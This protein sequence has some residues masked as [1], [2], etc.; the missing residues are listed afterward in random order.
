[1]ASDRLYPRYLADRLSAALSDTPVVVIHGPRQCG[2]TTLARAFGDSAGYSYITLD[3]PV[4]LSA[5]RADPTGFVLD[6][7][8]RAILDEVQRA[9][10]L[11]MPIKAS[12]DRERRPGRLILTGS[13]NMLFV[14]QIAD[15]LVG[16]ME[17]MRLHPLSQDEMA[18][19]RPR[20][21]RALF[22]GEFGL[23]R[24][25]RLGLGLVERI[26]AGGYPAAIRRASPSRRAA[27]YRDY[28]A[29]L[30][31]RDVRDLVRVGTREALGRLLQFAA[32]RN[33]Q[34]LNTADM[35]AACGV[36]RP[37]AGEY[38]SLLERLFLVDQLP[39]WHT[40]RLS[41]LV[42]APKLYLTDTG[43][44]CALIG[45]MA[46]AMWQSRSEMGPLL[47]AFVLQELRRQAS[48]LEE[49]AV[50][51][52]FR[53]RDG[54]EVD[55]VVEHGR[56]VVGLEVKAG[57]TVTSS[58]FRGLR[59]LRD[60]AGEAFIAGVILYDGEM[61]LGFGDRLFAVPVRAMWETV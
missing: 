45:L 52:H 22:A 56:T 57:A 9:P 5:A 25:E 33:G 15:A 1:M 11:F 61:S 23:Q 4:A 10:A 43:I 51:S 54:A 35:A 13:A 2:K 55:I 46:D 48:W 41:R 17:V 3:D 27:W 44:A 39:A 30:L 19:T 32:G 24:Y 34:L 36:S 6:L 59:K 8:A 20:F 7:P 37:T 26:V 12:V 29:A 58:D 53:D 38:M 21:I 16:R 18:G 50:L 47:E 40:N 28:V 31:E 14:S 60:A 49:P 42:K